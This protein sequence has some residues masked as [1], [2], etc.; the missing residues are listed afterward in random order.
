M[1]NP[2]RKKSS[3]SRITTML[4]FII[5]LFILFDPTLRNGLGQ[6]V[7]Y[8]LQPIIGFGGKYPVVTLFLAG[9]VMTGLT[10]IIR[11]FTVDYIEQVKS[12]KI[13]SAFN[14]EFRQA[15]LENNTYKIKKLTEQQPKILEKSMQVS[16]SQMK[17]LPITMIIVVPIFAWLSIFMIEIG[18]A[19]FAVPW[20][21]NANLNAVYV[22]PSWILLY[23]LISLP[24]GQVLA[25]VLRFFAFKKRLNQLKAGG[26]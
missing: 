24:F 23:S 18:S 13:V 15:R 25:R 6:L 3:T 11:H 21:H 10:V 26:E 16:S 7:G 22:L 20:S 1:A 2:D 4:V 14:K 12:Q 5:A 9:I 19:Y 8:G 17:L